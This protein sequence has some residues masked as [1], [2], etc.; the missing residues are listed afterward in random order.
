MKDHGTALIIG[1]GKPKN[2]PPPPPA[3]RKDI[4]GMMGMDDSKPN[5]DS[6]DDS[7]KKSP[8]EALVIRAGHDCDDCANYH[9]DSGECDKVSG[10][11]SPEDGC[12]RYFEP[13]GDDSDSSDD[14]QMSPESDD[15]DDSDMPGGYGPQ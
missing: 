1:I 7:G 5:D 4:P 15:S 2:G 6:A 12:L 14:D 8:E 10:Q 9:S 13:K 11:F 3:G